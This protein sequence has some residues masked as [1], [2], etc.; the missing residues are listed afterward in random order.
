MNLSNWDRNKDFDAWVPRGFAAASEDFL[1]ESSNSGGNSTWTALS[2]SWLEGDAPVSE[3]SISGTRSV[4]TLD[5]KTAGTGGW[6]W[7]CDSVGD[8][9]AWEDVSGD[10]SSAGVRVGSGAGSTSLLV[11]GEAIGGTGGEGRREIDR[12]RLGGGGG[13]VRVCVSDCDMFKDMS[14]SRCSTPVLASSAR[15]PTHVVCL[16]H[17]QKQHFSWFSILWHNKMSVE[18]SHLKFR[19]TRRMLQVA[20]RG[21]NRQLCRHRVR[22][23]RTEATSLALAER[24]RRLVL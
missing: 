8:E 12:R 3:D 1:I 20:A 23:C 6:I 21:H 18:N 13:R 16:C 19:H 22:Q 15:L 4:I 17:V 2:L 11:T 24:A 14:R 9:F 5:S 10:A 7:D